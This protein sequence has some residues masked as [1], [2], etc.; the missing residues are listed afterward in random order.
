VLESRLRKSRDLKRAKARLR[1][2][3]VHVVS[4]CRMLDVP[5]SC[6]SL[7]LSRLPRALLSTNDLQPEVSSSIGWK[8]TLRSCL[9]FCGMTSRRYVAAGVEA[10][11]R[12]LLSCRHELLTS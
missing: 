6:C 2:P 1:N 10:R 7:A 11:T 9:R 12:L 4:V 5:E 8:N 3:P